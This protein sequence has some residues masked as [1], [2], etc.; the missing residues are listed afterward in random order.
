MLSF[1]V[2]HHM[3]GF[4]GVYRACLRVVL[5]RLHDRLKCKIFLDNFQATS[6]DLTT[7]GGLYREYYQDGLNLRTEIVLS[8]P[9]LF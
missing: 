6:P 7:H 2:F 8:Y 5:G 9:D 1:G 3:F 4:S